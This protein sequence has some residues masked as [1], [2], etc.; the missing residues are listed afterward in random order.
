[1]AVSAQ[2]KAIRDATR[3]APPALARMTHRTRHQEYPNVTK[4]HASHGDEAR[5]RTHWAQTSGDTPW[6]RREE[7]AKGGRRRRRGGPPLP[8]HRSA[9]G[10]G[11]SSA[12]ATPRSFTQ[13]STNG[14][15]ALV[16]PAS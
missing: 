2:K 3:P 9:G 16:G 5:T 11:P 8:G 14:C 10:T 12:G 15:G 13:P 4:Y 6:R 1:V 7:H